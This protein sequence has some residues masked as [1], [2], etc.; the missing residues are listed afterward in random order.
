MNQVSAQEQ[1]NLSP[2]PKLFA[3]ALVTGELWQ[4]GSYVPGSELT[5]SRGPDH[6]EI[7]GTEGQ[8]A[9]VIMEMFPNEDGSVEV[10]ASPVPGSAFD[11]QQTGAVFTLYPLTIQRLLTVARFDVWKQMLAEAQADALDPGEDPEDPENPD[12]D[13]TPAPAG[14][15][16]A[17][18]GAPT[19]GA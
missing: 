4:L 10:F 11:R 7:E 3:V 12:D 17:T 8:Q 15:L 9:L 5:K 14:A 1:P 2:P 19:A 18:N 6:R 16:P 13:V